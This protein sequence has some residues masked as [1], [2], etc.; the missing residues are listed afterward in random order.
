M[1]ALYAGIGGAKTGI[2][3]VAPIENKGFSTALKMRQRST[4]AFGH[5]SAA[6]TTPNPNK[7]RTV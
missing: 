7:G 4:I 5:E 1:S 3:E 6:I 2:N